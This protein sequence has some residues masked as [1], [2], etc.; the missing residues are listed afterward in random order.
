MLPGEPPVHLELTISRMHGRTMERSSRLI[1]ARDV[2]VRR[3][4]EIEKEQLI[5]KL[6]SAREDVKTLSGLLPICAACKKVRDD[7][8]YWTQLEQ[9]ITKHS[10]ATFSHGLCPECMRKLYPDLARDIEEEK[11]Q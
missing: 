4:I 9:Y 1:V 2:S 11:K 5:T 6:T 3:R 8:G 10:Q 7:T